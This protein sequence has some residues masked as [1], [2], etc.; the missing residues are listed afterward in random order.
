MDCLVRSKL[1]VGVLLGNGAQPDFLNLFPPL[2]ERDDIY[3]LPGYLGHFLNGNLCIELR[4][5]QLRFDDR[6][7][8]SV[9]R[10]END[11]TIAHVEG[12]IQ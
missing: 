6:T 2:F 8:V 3:W 11:S 7:V 4:L 5:L 10:P 1:K 9:A 12:P